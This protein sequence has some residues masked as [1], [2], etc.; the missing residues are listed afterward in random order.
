MSGFDLYTFPET[1]RAAAEPPS[2]IGNITGA[3]GRLDLG[4]PINSS[5]R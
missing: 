4:R 2:N 3:G 5:V 1:G